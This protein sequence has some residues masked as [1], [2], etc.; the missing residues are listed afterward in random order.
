AA[1]AK[2]L[3]VCAGAAG[4]AAACVATG[5]LPDPLAGG[6]PPPHPAIERAADNPVRDAA[7]EYEPAPAP[8]PQPNPP[9]KR[10]PKDEAEDASADVAATPT[11]AVEYEAP[12]PVE[13]PPP[14]TESAPAPPSSGSAAGEFGP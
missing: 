14:V 7:V 3:A 5:V 6:N 9:A 12:P 1:L 11:G 2:L 10:E 13:V 4:G 8:E